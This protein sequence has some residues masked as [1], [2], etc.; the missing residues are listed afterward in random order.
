MTLAGTP[1]AIEN[2]GMS[3]VTTLPAPIIEASPIVIPP[4][5]VALLPIETLFLI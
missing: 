4:I 1:A 5:I 3:E 2:G